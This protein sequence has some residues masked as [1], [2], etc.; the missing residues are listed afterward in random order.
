LFAPIHY[1]PNYAYPLLVWF[2]EPGTDEQQLLHIMP[3][4][5][6]RN[7]VAAAPRGLPIGE[8]RWG[9]PQTVEAIHETEQRVAETIEAVEQRYHVAE[10]RI[11]VAGFGAGGTMALRLALASPQRFA[12]AVSLCGAL[13]AGHTPLGRLNEARRLPVL[14]AVAR[15]SCVYPPAAACNDL[16]LLHTAGLLTTLRQYHPGGQQLLPHMLGDLNRWIMEQVTANRGV[17]NAE[18]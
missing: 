17:L 4:V 14:L 15:D 7:Y 12:G 8:G 2:H 13:P 5:S 10:D 18:C 16:R 6:V 3:A 9:W 1:E 11:F